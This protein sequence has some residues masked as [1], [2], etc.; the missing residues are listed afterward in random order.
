MSTEDAVVCVDLGKSRCRVVLRGPHGDIAAGTR[1]G[2][3]GLAVADAPERTA[4][5]LQS[6]LAEVA[7]GTAPTSFGIGAAGA[8]TSPRGADELARL[9]A[10][11]Y[12]VPVAVASDIVTA[13]VGAFDGAPG[14]CLVAGTGAVALGVAVDGSTARFDGLG[15]L[16]GDVGS[17]AWIGRAGLRAAELAAAGAAAPTRLVDL[18]SSADETAPASDGHTAAHL[19][20]YAPAVLAAAEDGD[21]TALAIVTAA[22][23]ELAA[24]AQAAAL[25][26]DQRDVSVLGGLTGSELF[27]SALTTALSARELNRRMPAGTALDGARII[28]TRHDLPLKGLIHRA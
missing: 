26:T 2:L 17:G 7:P 11:T 1:D 8:L 13:H 15:L 6:L 28:A 23:T 18:I 27:S 9:L 19:A 3:P 21:T 4:R 16:A 22:V 12:S 20:R 24:T 14:V 5:V 10:V 25:A